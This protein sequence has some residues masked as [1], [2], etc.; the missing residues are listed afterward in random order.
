MKQQQEQTLHYF[1]TTVEGWQ[2]KS[3]NQAGKFS[4]VEGRNSAVLDVVKHKKAGTAFLDVGCGT[5]QLVIDVA[6][7]GWQAEGID[8][9]P[10][11]IAQCEA[12]AKTAE[13]APKFVAD[14][15]Y[16]VRLPDAHYDVI[17][18]QGFI[19]YVSA[20][21]MEEFFQRSYRSLK[22]GGSL[23]VGSR[24]R[25]FNIVSLNDFTRQERD[26]G[27]LDILILEAMALQSSASM[28]DAMTS[29]HRFER[30]DPQPDR[31]PITGVKVETRY[32]YSPA[33]LSYRLRRAGFTLRTLYPVHFH[34]LPPAMKNEQAD[35]HNALANAAREIGF[36][37]HRLVPSSSSFVVDAVKA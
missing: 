3:V 21:E 14:S 5:G 6:K 1:N 27:V 32:Q 22:P 11:M 2:Q 29:L 24:N 26:L 17:S 30:I 25:L 34:G 23:A 16:N 13:V 20:D 4:I 15:F 19:E 35:F 31:H 12:N 7:L 10:E 8:F 18:A 33:E 36:K 28:A 37:D 9:A